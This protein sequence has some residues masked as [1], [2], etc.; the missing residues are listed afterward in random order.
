MGRPLERL[1]PAGRSPNDR[2]LPGRGDG[3]AGAAA[4]FTSKHTDA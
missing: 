1:R 3:H 2:S 4:Q